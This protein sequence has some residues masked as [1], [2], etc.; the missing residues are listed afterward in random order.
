MCV[1]GIDAS[2]WDLETFLKALHILFEDTP[3]RRE[4]YLSVTNK[5]IAESKEAFPQ[6]WCSHR[7]LENTSVAQRALDILPNI[8]VYIQ[9]VQDKK[10][11][12]PGT[13]TF[14]T[15]KCAVMKDPL[16]PSKLACFISISKLVEPFLKIYQTDKVMIPYLAEDLEVLLRK[17]IGRFKKLEGTENGVKL[18]GLN[19]KE[20]LLD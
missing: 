1:A 10:V 6:K 8:K 11:K 9:A 13:K 18:V 12:D 4:D 14:D 5:G 19:L 20:N 2:G 7:W 15:V 3:A 17:I 16:L